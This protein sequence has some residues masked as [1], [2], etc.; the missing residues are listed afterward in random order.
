MDGG[1]MNNANGTSNSYSRDVVRDVD[2]QDHLA[3]LLADIIE[4]QERT[5]QRQMQIVEHIVRSDGKRNRLGD[6]QKLKPPTFLGTSNPLEAEDWII[7][8][9]KAFDAMDCTDNERVSFATFMLQSSAFEWWDAHRKS[10]EQG[11]Q[12]TWKLFKEDFY[13]KYFPES[14]KRIKEKEFLELKQGHKSVSDYE[15]EFSRLARFAPAFVQT[16]SSKARRFESGL[17]QPLKRRVEAFELNSFREVVNKAQLM[18]KGYHEEKKEID[19]PSKKMKVDHQHFDYER[20][21]NFGHPKSVNYKP[22][23]R[24]CPICEEDHRP[25]VCPQRWGRCYRCG[26]P[27]HTQDW[28]HLLSN[29]TFHKEKPRAVMLPA[30]SQQLYLPGPPQAPNCSSDASSHGMPSK[31]S[32]QQPNNGWK[33]RGGNRARVYNLVKNNEGE[34]HNEVPGPKEAEV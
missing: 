24:S 26:E 28:C 30:P 13:Q 8:M 27:G 2:G 34:L 12:I 20:E 18:E 22:Q 15:I 31:V 10:Y 9:E 19:Q 33:N 5:Q 3:H 32:R 16:D 6:F 11:V 21:V 29:S 23:E 7:A 25:N 14:V 1:N 4:K 17:R